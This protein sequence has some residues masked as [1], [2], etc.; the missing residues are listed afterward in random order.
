MSCLRE[1]RNMQKNQTLSLVEGNVGL[2]LIYA[3]VAL[4]KS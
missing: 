1:P 4:M 3:G 2:L